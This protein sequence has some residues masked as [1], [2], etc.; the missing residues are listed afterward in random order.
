M[1]TKQSSLL[2]IRIFQTLYQQ[3]ASS[4]IYN[5]LLWLHSAIKKCIILEAVKY[6]CFI[7]LHILKICSDI[8]GW[9]VC[10]ASLCKPRSVAN[11]PKVNAEKNHLKTFAS[12]LLSYQAKQTRYLLAWAVLQPRTV[13]LPYRNL[14]PALSYITEFLYH[15]SCSH[16]WC[17]RSPLSQTVIATEQNCWH[18]KK[19]KKRKKST[20][21]FQ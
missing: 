21:D 20:V 9:S 7:R 5:H 18:S 10:L 2:W 12:F 15:R 11:E 13:T 16:V 14:E 19:K 8:V 4:W 17:W 3:R 6:L 1:K